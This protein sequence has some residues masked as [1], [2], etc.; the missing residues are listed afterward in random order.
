M[1]EY[2]TARL[3]PSGP[4]FGQI[5]IPETLT[6]A[7]FDRCVLDLLDLAFPYLGLRGCVVI[8]FSDRWM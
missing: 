4:P 8:P 2:R 6:P 3:A 5:R 7:F 1:S